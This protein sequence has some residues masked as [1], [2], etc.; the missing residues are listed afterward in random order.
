MKQLI[1]STVLCS[2]VSMMACVQ[3][4]VASEKS[5]IQSIVVKQGNEVYGEGQALFDFFKK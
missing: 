4:V 5:P 2:V 3:P 1:L